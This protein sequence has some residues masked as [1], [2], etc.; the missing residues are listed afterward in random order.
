MADKL[1]GVFFDVKTIA[2]VVLIRTFFIGAGI[3]NAKMFIF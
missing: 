2:F 1:D 3:H